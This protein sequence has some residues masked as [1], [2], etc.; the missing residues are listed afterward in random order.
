[1]LGFLYQDMV[2]IGVNLDM[3][4]VNDPDQLL[5]LE[6]HSAVESTIDSQ[7]P[8][9]GGAGF[10][11]EETGNAALDPVSAA[12]QQRYASSTLQSQLDQLRDSPGGSATDALIQQAAATIDSEM[13][14][15]NFAAI[16]IQNVTRSDVTGYAAYTQPV[17][18]YENLHPTA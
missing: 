17:V 10:L 16:P 7:T 15:I 8:L 12:A 4:Y 9:L 6:Q 14:T 13:A 2:E 1:V 5:A 18:Y 3:S 11:L